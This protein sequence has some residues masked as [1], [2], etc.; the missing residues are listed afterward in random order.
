MEFSFNINTFLK[1]EITV[2]DRNHDLLKY[3]FNRYPKENSHKE[4]L[5]EVINK[6]G[7]NSAQA[8]GL[9]GAVTS[10]ELLLVA[11]QRC[12]I[13]KDLNCTRPNGTVI[14]F[15]KV[16]A[17][18]LFFINPDSNQVEVTPLCVLDFYVNEARQ[19]QG[20]GYKLF[21]YMMENENTSPGSLAIDRP[22][23]KMLGFYK[24]KFNLSAPINQ[25]NNFVVFRDFFSSYVPTTS[26]QWPDHLKRGP[27]KLK[28]VPK[29]LPVE[30][31]SF[32]PSTLTMPLKPKTTTPVSTNSAAF[33]PAVFNP[34]ACTPSAFIPAARGPVPAAFIPAARGP[35]ACNSPVTNPA[36]CKEFHMPSLLDRPLSRLMSSSAGSSGRKTSSPTTNQAPKSGKSR[37]STFNWSRNNV[38]LNRNYIVGGQTNPISQSRYTHFGRPRPF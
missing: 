5:K 32:F 1:D 17:K 25:P 9:N 16:G 24:K 34:A 2:I 23:E 36:A 14:G 20:H 8:Q 4:E 6:L 15:L 22:S 33:N 11:E 18:K 10:V 38:M 30:K 3:S 29:L 31:E 28:A 13:L 37:D 35:A 19:R 12:Y 7:T 21:S 26:K 27:I